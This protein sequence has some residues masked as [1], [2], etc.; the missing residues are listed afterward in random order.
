MELSTKILG[1]YTGCTSF[2]RPEKE[3]KYII[4]GDSFENETL[5]EQQLPE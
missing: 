5:P 3:V 2:G 4:K 1:A